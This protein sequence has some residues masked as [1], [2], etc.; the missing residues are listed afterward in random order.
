M[1]RPRR[2]NRHRVDG[3]DGRRRHAPWQDPYPGTIWIADY[4]LGNIVV[5]QPGADATLQTRIR[6]LSRRGQKSACDTYLA[7]RKDV[8]ETSRKLRR[9]VGSQIR[10][11]ISIYR[12]ASMPGGRQFSVTAG[13]IFNESRQSG[14]AGNAGPASFRPPEWNQL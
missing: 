14:Q 4:G 13:T 3:P 7:E 1:P 6:G 10:K 5:L 12:S 8:Q 11:Y 9:F 2:H